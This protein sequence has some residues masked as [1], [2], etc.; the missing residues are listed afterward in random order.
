MGQIESK[1]FISKLSIPVVTTLHTISPNFNE[2]AQIV[3]KNISEK[4]AKIVTMSSVG[5]KI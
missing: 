1:I 2:K 5:K 4:S 3:L